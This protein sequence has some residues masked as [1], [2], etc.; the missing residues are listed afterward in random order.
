GGK[1]HRDRP[2]QYV[3]K[4]RLPCPGVE[5]LGIVQPVGDVVRIE[6]HGGRDGGAGKRPA[7]GLVRAGDGPVAFAA[8]NALQR[9]I[10]PDGKLEEERRIRARALHCAAMLA[11]ALILRKAF[12]PLGR[13]G[14]APSARKGQGGR[15]E[16]VS[17]GERGAR[18]ASAAPR[19]L[20]A[21][22]TDWRAGA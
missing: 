4:D 20:R 11:S 7:P 21:S 18:A 16:S 2:C 10:R 22:S 17:V 19:R 14:K 13:G 12:P 8:R 9:E 1:R 5:T 6:D 3:G 15:T